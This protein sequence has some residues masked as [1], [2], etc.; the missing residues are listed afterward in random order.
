MLILGRIYKK[1]RFTNNDKLRFSSNDMLVLG[2]DIDSKIYEKVC[3]YRGKFRKE[4]DEMKWEV[5]ALTGKQTT[6]TIDRESSIELL[7]ILAIIFIVINH[8]VQTL[9]LENIYIPYQDYVLDFT[10]A[11]TNVQH[12]LLIIFSYFGPWGN[13]I[14]F[15]CSAWFLLKSPKCNKKKWFFMLIEIWTISV[16][17]LIITYVLS[18]GNISTKIIL[19]SL[20]PTIFANNWYLTCYLLFYPI[21]PILNGVIGRMGKQ[22]LFRIAVAMFIL[23]YCLDFIWNEWF[24]PSAIIL[25]ITIYFIIAYIQLYL[26]DFADSAKYN[27]ILLVFGLIGFVGIAILTNYLGLHVSF[28]ENKMLH[29]AVNCNPFLFACS[30]AMFNIARNIHFKNYLINYISKLSLL[31]YIIHENLILRT[32]YRPYMMNYI[33]ENYGYDNIIAWVFALVI[34]IFVFALVFATIY[35]RT[36]QRFVQKISNM[37]Y[38]IFRRVYLGFEQHAF[39]FH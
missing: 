34:V 3:I 6:K 25:W 11:T 27:L 38:T 23:Y 36:L 14:F 37:L 13:T 28:M 20:L 8:V 32:Y 16:I 7:K 12:F 31:I 19:K 39:K 17:I 18:H 1:E 33:Y 2:R 30:V 24:F 35:E 21:H 4:V 29:W 15:V 10:I 22:D 26:I 9:Q 5:H